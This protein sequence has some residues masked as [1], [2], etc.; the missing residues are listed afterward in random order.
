MEMDPVCVCGGGGCVWWCV[1]V[2][3]V[4]VW[5]GV[6]VCVCV[7][8]G[9][10]VCV[11]VCVVWCVCVCG[12]CVVCVWLC[13]C[14]CVVC[15]CVCGVCVCVCVCG[16]CVFVCVC[17]CVCVCECVVFGS[18]CSWT[19]EPMLRVLVGLGVRLPFSVQ[20]FLL[21]ESRVWELLRT[22]L[23]MMGQMSHSDCFSVNRSV[24][25]CS[26]IC[27]RIAVL[28]SDGK[29]NSKHHVVRMGFR[30]WWLWLGRQRGRGQSANSE[31]R[32]LKS[33][34][35]I[36]TAQLWYFNYF[37]NLFDSWFYVK[38]IFICELIYIVH[39]NWL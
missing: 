26:S 6:C 25:Y 16:V 8:C 3:C 19:Q 15:V 39:T 5:C 14:V 9:V 4:C 23:L 29:W 36:K 30:L 28:W 24:V 1:C 31:A 11:C 21:S 12:V 37:S 35:T 34:I 18:I 2:V 17:V 22:E 10:C 27:T 33:L 7:V 32:W 38:C 20:L 13:V